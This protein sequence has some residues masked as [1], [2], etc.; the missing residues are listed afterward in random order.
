[1]VLPL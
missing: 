1:V